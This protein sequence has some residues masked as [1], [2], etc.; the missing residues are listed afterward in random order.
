VTGIAERRRERGRGRQ[1]FL[2]TT[3]PVLSRHHLLIDANGKLGA[4]PGRKIAVCGG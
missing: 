1:G 3:A 4:S 2:K